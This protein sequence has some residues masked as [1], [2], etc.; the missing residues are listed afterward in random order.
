M[1]TAASLLAASIIGLASPSMP[2]H[3]SGSLAGSRIRIVPQTSAGLLQDIEESLDGTRLITHD[4]GYAPRLWDAKRQI[5][6]TVLSGH[7]DRISQV[8]F[9]PDGGKLLTLSPSEIRIW[10]SI[11][12]KMIAVIPAKGADWTIA[13]FSTDGSKLLV[14]NKGGSVFLTDS[15]APESIRELGKHK[16][17]VVSLA[18]A[19]TAKQGFSGAQD[20]SGL[21]W[22]FVA[23]KL[24][25]Q[26]TDHTK[27]LRWAFYNDSSTHLITTGEDDRANVYQADGK[28]VGSYAHRIGER[29]IENVNMG[30][31]FVGKGD[32][33]VVALPNGHMQIIPV[34]SKTPVHTFTSH[35]AEI[36]ELRRSRDGRY[37]ATYASDMTLRIWDAVDRKEL[38]FTPEDGDP[39]AGEFSPNSPVWWLGYMEGEIRKYNVLTG[40]A[41]KATYGEVASAES[42]EL[43]SDNSFAIHSEGGASS[44][45]D[46]AYGGAHLVLNPSGGSGF[47]L[48]GGW[49]T[50]K[51]SPG[52]RF[53]AVSSRTRD[54]GFVI[55]DV[56][57]Q[58]PTYWIE[59]RTQGE[60]SADSSKFVFPGQDGVVEIVDPK[61][62][63]PLKAWKFKMDENAGDL[64]NPTFHPNGDW[65]VSG[66]HEGNGVYLWE[67][68]TGTVVKSF[69]EFTDLIDRFVFSKDG[70]RLLIV[71]W[72]ELRVMD[73]DSGATIL[74]LKGSQATPQLLTDAELTRIVLPVYEGPTE[75]YDALSG[76]KLGEIKHPGRLLALSPDIKK[77][78]M[79]Q[80]TVAEVVEIESGKVLSQMRNEDVVKSSQFVADGERVLTV[81]KTGGV[82][83]WDNKGER[84]CS[85][86]LMKNGEWLA[87]DDE[88]RFDASNPSNVQGAYF[89]L[90]WDGGLEP[91]AMP[92]L[93]A[94]FYDPKLLAKY[95]G[96]ED[97][98]LRDVPNLDTLK[99]YPELTVQPANAEGRIDILSK[100]RDGGGVGRVTAY[101]NGKQVGFKKGSTYWRFETKEFT[102][103]MLPQS[104]LPEGKGNELS[105]TVSNERGD[106]TSAPV[107]VDL[108]VPDGLKAP[109]VK[110]YALFV[111]V[112]D[113]AGS[114]GDLLAPPSDA[115]DLA[116]A[117]KEVGEKL[118]PGKVEVSALT[119]KDTDGA[120]RPTRANIVNWFKS[121]A[122][123]ATSSDIVM[124]FF[125]GHGTS[126]IGE[127]GGYFFLTSEANP[128]DIS[129]SSVGTAT[130]SGDDL[131][132]SLNTIA[133]N[134][135]VVILDTCHSGAASE[136]LLGAGR[137]VSGEYQRAWESIKDTTGT[138][139]LAGSAADQLSYE[140]A[141]VDHGML[142]YALLE[143]I[144]KGS[145]EGLRQVPSGELF[146]DVERWLNYAANRVESLKSEVGLSGVQRPEFKRATQGSTFDIG[147]LSPEK[148]GFIGLK[149]PMPIVIVGSFELDEEDPLNLEAA[150]TAAMRD[151]RTLKPWFNV[152]KHPNVYR[153]AGSYTLE[154]EKVRVRLLIQTLDSAQVR[155]TA[156]TVE[157]EGS[158]RDL[159]GL[160]KAIREAAE[161]KIAEI[162]KAKSA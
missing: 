150:V 67:W 84:L 72:N 63:K 66:N 99:L 50:V 57:L 27:S 104:M 111:G 52:G 86:V 77:V 139:L 9:S 68:Q 71:G 45:E 107:T 38:P 90:D 135:Q 64:E 147:V 148:K 106:L 137:S 23:N 141:N 160:S 18:Y 143:A 16:A 126:K 41:T 47:F 15:L 117:V 103:F 59:M 123:K 37:L 138:W 54:T 40:R 142:T 124:T 145:A 133:A 75:V 81:D 109:E 78:V 101:L 96:I 131:R 20:G 121:V 146:V 125:A 8:N 14:G 89:V 69:G 156:A 113:Y 110:L 3:P 108:G 51:L 79:A 5:L 122:S 127:Q 118:L 98:P 70:K 73:V 26:T 60:F 76:K 83:I 1:L 144:D 80:D 116:A 2:D 29:G 151:T 155:K 4:R 11:R 85:M 112:G 34:G 149:P 36:R 10:D 82:Q 25:W 129:V 6:L 134:K 92:Q 74:D 154:G 30:A 136:S 161:Q 13:Q 42:A 56:A 35:K 33:I 87:Y 94:Q 130:I 97:E 158:N 46:W 157:L 61:A 12:A 44:L 53:A 88:G 162:E 32:E 39:T 49:D 48:N 119:T 24:A 22:D 140:S 55:F 91:I 7:R 43:L 93:K 132:E 58:K 100:E 102:S 28:N 65:I 19:P 159:P 21:A 120:K 152:Q 115:Q 153:M 128:G 95:L 114:G 62:G 31:Q 105:V 17:A